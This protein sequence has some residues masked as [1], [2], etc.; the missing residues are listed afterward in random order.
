M[1]KLARSTSALTSFYLYFCECAPQRPEPATCRA[2]Q[3]SA[4][5]SEA[6]CTSDEQDIEEI[7]KLKE[8]MTSLPIKVRESLEL[9]RKK[10]REH[11]RYF[12]ALQVRG[13]TCEDYAKVKQAVDIAQGRLIDINHRLTGYK[14]QLETGNKL[15]GLNQ[16]RLSTEK[17]FCVMDCESGERRPDRSFLCEKL[18][19]YFITSTVSLHFTYRR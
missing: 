3:L 1:V 15:R 7:I 18:W 5:G 12:E 13:R 6:S 9:D 4:P 8:V 16:S 14:N 2:T 10:Q 19:D 17:I 11:L